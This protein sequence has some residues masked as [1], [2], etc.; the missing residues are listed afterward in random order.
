M[1][2]YRILSQGLS[3]DDRTFTAEI[4]LGND[5]H[6]VNVHS[7]NLTL[8]PSLEGLL[9]MGLLP[10]MKTGATMHANGPVSPRFLEG[11]ARNQHL[12]R[13]WKPGYHPVAIEGAQLQPPHH[14]QAQRVGT[15]FSTGVD[16]SYTFI[17]HQSEI[18]DLIY[19]AGF[20]ITRGDRS[21][22]AQTA[23]SAR[24]VA[25]H[26]NVNLV[27]LETN[28]RD[29][30]DRYVF[31]GMAHG[32]AMVG[33]GHLLSAHFRRIYVAASLDLERQIHWGT[34]PE[35]DNNW[36]SETL[37]F[38][39]DGTEARRID[40]ITRLA[41]E[42]VLLQ[43]LRVCVYPPGREL[44]CGRCEK[45]IRTMIALQAVGALEHCSA[46]EAPLDSRRIYRLYAQ[47]DRLHTAF[48]AENLE[49]LEKNGRDPALAATLRRVQRIP[50][51]V[52]KL[53]RVV[54]RMHGGKPYRS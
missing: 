34:H 9:S 44:N 22:Y 3:S 49:A 26:Y 21:Q 36:S 12:F 40:K 4:E 43:N 28:I 52:K 46:F 25:E 39:H 8:A 2:E 6:M 50:W 41:S 32:T 38:I 54:R 45:C 18:T 37:E 15:F 31:W 27:I 35:L 53:L 47:E 13:F 11:Q 14:P 19:L 23:E 20:D 17:N 29:F 33:I 7:N 30:M 48:I 10:S 42:P 1:S 5:R 24:R 16:S 51:P